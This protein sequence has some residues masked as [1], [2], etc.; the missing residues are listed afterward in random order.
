[1][2][3][4]VF[5]VVTVFL[6]MIIPI[7][8]AHTNAQSEETLFTIPDTPT[9]LNAV[10]NLPINLSW[11]AS[12][13]PSSQAPVTHYSIERSNNG[14]ETWDVISLRIEITKPYSHVKAETITYTDSNVVIGNIYD[15]RVKAHNIVGESVPSIT[16]NATAILDMDKKIITFGQRAGEKFVP[17][18]NSEIYNEKVMT[19]FEKNYILTEDDVKEIFGSRWEII[20]TENMLDNTDMF[21][22]KII[23]KDATQFFDP[24]LQ[25]LKLSSIIVEVY[26]FDDEFEQEEFWYMEEYDKTIFDVALM[27]GFSQTTGSCFFENSEKG[28]MSGCSYDDIII[29]VSIFDPYMQHYR[30]NNSEYSENDSNLRNEP[31]LKIVN[32]I[33]EKINNS[34][35]RVYTGNL[36]DVLYND[37]TEN[38]INDGMKDMIDSGMENSTDPEIALKA[39]IN[40]F[41]CKKNDFGIVSIAG[42]FVNGIGFINDA[43]ITIGIT[44]QNEN[45]ITTD[46][47]HFHNVEKYDTRKFVAYIKT[48][49]KFYDCTVEITS[50]DGLLKYKT[51]LFSN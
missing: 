21:S 27:S 18:P 41:T 36:V 13:D 20:K 8:L 14:G 26:Q 2:K 24:I 4:N 48:D 29:Q 39:G 44:D 43:K 50:D 7:S 45:V 19:S 9:N 16:A 17:D 23:L 32:K 5:F 28:G 34:K 47:N 1:M 6:V 30:Y 38:T 3:F 10:T 31:T 33:L 46:S 35:H 11:T 51:S 12:S 42:E 25:K 22:S 49:E 37:Q 15:Y 40:H